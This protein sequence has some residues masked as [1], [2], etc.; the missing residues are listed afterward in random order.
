MYQLFIQ[1]LLILDFNA[2]M[3][4]ATDKITDDGVVFMVSYNVNITLDT[5]I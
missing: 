3:R 4:I 2:V 1:I 5:T